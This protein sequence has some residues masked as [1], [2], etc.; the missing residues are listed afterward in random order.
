MNVPIR[1][2]PRWPPLW[3][4]HDA[5][6]QKTAYATLANAARGIFDTPIGQSLMLVVRLQVI[7]SYHLISWR[8]MMTLPSGLTVRMMLMPRLG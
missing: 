1:T 8:F 4:F 7:K 5:L 2:T 3:E 6:G